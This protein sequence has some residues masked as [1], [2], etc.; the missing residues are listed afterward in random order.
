MT[1]KIP[2]YEIESVGGGVV[3]LSTVAGQRN[4]AQSLADGERVA[5]VTLP[6]LRTLGLNDTAKSSA[7]LWFEE[8]LPLFRDR[9]MQVLARMVD[10][11]SMSA[12]A[13]RS[14]RE[15]TRQDYP[16]VFEDFDRYIAECR[17]E[18]ARIDALD[19]V[20]TPS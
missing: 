17:A 4:A 20:P 1:I 15:S 10:A 2:L 14:F 8:P 5:L 19:D 12:E 7:Y 13:G 3:T 11:A 6:M 16:D 9:R 18:S